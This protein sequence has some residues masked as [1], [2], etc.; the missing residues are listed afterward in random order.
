MSLISHSIQMPK[1]LIKVSIHYFSAF[2]ALSKLLWHSEA[3]LPTNGCSGSS[4][5]AIS[6]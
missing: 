5:G 3:V 2:T 1:I 6:N 4:S